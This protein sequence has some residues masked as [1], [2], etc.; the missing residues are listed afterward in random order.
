MAQS[1]PRSTSL[2]LVQT[3]PGLAPGVFLWLMALMDKSLYSDNFLRGI[4]RETKTIAA[5][6]VSANTVRPSW[7]V[8]NY[9]HLRGYRIIPLNPGL[10]GQTLFG[11]TAYARLSEIPEATG[12]IHMVDLFRRSE[13]VLPIVEEALDTLLDRGLK[14]IWMQIGVVNE[15]AALLAEKAGLNVIMNRC[16][17]M[18]YQRLMGELSKGGINTGIISSKLVR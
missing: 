7:F 12:D 9:M 4:L 16:P 5:V 17:K 14:T 15:D 11:E 1:E 13:H 18:E 3:S 2:S 8:C 6:G 10:A